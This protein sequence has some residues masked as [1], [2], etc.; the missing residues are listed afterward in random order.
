MI[1]SQCASLSNWTSRLWPTE[2]TR[3]PDECH[4]TFPIFQD[5]LNNM[6]MPACTIKWYT[7]TKWFQ[8][9][10][11][12]KRFGLYFPMFSHRVFLLVVWRLLGET[13]RDQPWLLAVTL[14]HDATG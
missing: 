2:L 8:H 12:L 10:W 14:P 5:N 3:I 1:L 6:E 13:C 11:I 9:V 7:S 4:R